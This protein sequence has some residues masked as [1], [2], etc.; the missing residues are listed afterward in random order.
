M[1]VQSL[2][3]CNQ[4]RAGKAVDKAPLSLT[5]GIQMVADAGHRSEGEDRQCPACG[6]V[7]VVVPQVQRRV[8]P[9]V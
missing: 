4:H 5:L 1:P 7:D 6:L 9:R 3:I 8:F 2:Q